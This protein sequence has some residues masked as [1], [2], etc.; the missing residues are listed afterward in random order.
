MCPWVDRAPQWYELELISSFGFNCLLLTRN[1]TLGWPAVL[2]YSNLTT[3]DF[4]TGVW[5]PEVLYHGLVPWVTSQSRIK[6]W[7]LGSTEI[8]TQERGRQVVSEAES[9]M[10]SRAGLPELLDHLPSHHSG[11][12]SHCLRYPSSR[13]HIRPIVL[14]QSK[15]L[16]LLVIIF[17]QLQSNCAVLQSPMFPDVTVSLKYPR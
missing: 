15:G 3:N 10:L 1:P 8:K 4:I 13:N 16:L 7:N 11:K 9:A 2:D 5:V 12:T 14:K 6:N 17:S